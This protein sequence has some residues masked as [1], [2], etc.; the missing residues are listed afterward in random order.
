MNFLALL[1]TLFHLKLG[2]TSEDQKLAR[3]AGG[4]KLK[5]I[6]ENN[7]NGVEERMEGILSIPHC[8]LCASHAPGRLP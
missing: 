7:L 3:N 5:G 2:Q 4:F 8:P 1:T 6:E